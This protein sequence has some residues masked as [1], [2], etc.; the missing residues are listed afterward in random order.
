MKVLVFFLF[1]FVF[2]PK[3][4]A[5]SSSPFR[6]P[7]SCGSSNSFANCS[8]S[9]TSDNARATFTGSTGYLV[10]R[11]FGFT[12]PLNAVITSFDWEIEGYAVGSGGSP[13]VRTAEVRLHMEGSPSYFGSISPSCLSIPHGSLQWV[14]TDSEQT[15][16]KN[17]SVSCYTSH[18]ITPSDVNSP[19][20]GLSIMT[21]TNGSPTYYIDRVRLRVNY[22][23]SG[24]GFATVITRS[25]ASPSG[26]FLLLD[27]EGE[28][29]TVSSRMT[30]K[31][32]LFERC[33]RPG[34]AGWTSQTSVATIYLYG[35]SSAT[36]TR[37][38]APGSYQGYGWGP[39]QRTWQAKGVKVPYN[40]GYTCDYPTF[41]I[42]TENNEI[43][44]E[45]GFATDPRLV[46]T[47]SA[48]AN[49]LFSE[50]EPTNPIAWLLW[51]LRQTFW[52][53]FGL[54]FDAMDVQ[55]FALTRDNFNSRIPFAYVNAVF[56]LD[57]SPPP[58][59]TASPILSMPIQ[60]SA[61]SSSLSFSGSQP[62]YDFM[63]LVRNGLKIL[64]WSFF[65]AYLFFLSRR[66]FK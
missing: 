48:Q 17:F 50:P 2:V 43:V 8:N 13:N 1:F 54:R 64:L 10:I 27:L 58:S 46:A 22:T 23:L 35:G 7:S 59:S 34:Y 3:V 66:I 21:N 62:F 12:L 16:S 40:P 18:T 39:P 60:S 53:F 49:T 6:E 41:Y 33:S 31:I 61:I 44:A 15:T 24:A 28:T 4:Y 20:F 57:F 38:I 9:F 14:P 26:Q 37:E 25:E 30:C 36:Q 63:A 47:P 56:S 29:A 52:E 11:D 51:K 42:C 45:A 19:N 65:V 32:S 5:S 55:Y